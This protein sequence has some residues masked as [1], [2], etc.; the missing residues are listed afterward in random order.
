MLYDRGTGRLFR[1]YCEG[2]AA[3]DAFADDY[4]FLAQAL[5]DLFE[6]TGEPR[7]LQTAFELC[8]RGLKS[9][10]DE[11]GGGF[12]STRADVPD[13]LLRLKDEYDGAEPSVNSI[14][15]DVLLRVAHLTDNMEFRQMAER[16]LAWLTP[17]LR[18]QSAVSPQAVAAVMR[19]FVE[20]AQI[21]IR[22]AESSAA[23]RLFAGE[24]R[25]QFE[26]FT[27]VLLLPDASMSGLQP[28]APFLSNLRRDGR[29]TVFECR[30]FT[31]L[32]PQSRAC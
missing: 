6:I 32:L 25:R 28:F 27:A 26:P 3:I 30:N 1:R 5:L 2:E 21:V 31:C 11:A 20:P 7:Y 17:R 29:F 12:F 24:K 23:A 9:F 15:A 16:T 19:S 8:Q 18:A 10:E 13:V 14:A 4:A 22:C